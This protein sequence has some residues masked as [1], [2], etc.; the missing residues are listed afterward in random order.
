MLWEGGEVWAVWQGHRGAESVGRGK[1]S[2][3]MGGLMADGD[4]EVSA[5]LMFAQ[6]LDRV[7]N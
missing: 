6:D 7:A 2:F 4:I 1:I 5:R 3:A